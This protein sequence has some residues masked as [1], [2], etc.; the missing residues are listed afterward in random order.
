MVLISKKSYQSGATQS[1]DGFDKI[2]PFHLA[3]TEQ[4]DVITILIP[5]RI[6]L[7]LASYRKQ[8]LEASVISKDTE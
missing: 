7:S 4:I 3:N 6:M 2:C 5:P 1:I 8:Y